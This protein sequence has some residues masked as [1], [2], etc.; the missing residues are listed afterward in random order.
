[1]K[2][3]LAPTPSGFLHAGNGAAFVLAWKLAR[4]AGGRLLLRIDDLDA[5][6]VRPEY[7]KDVFDTLAWLGIEPDEGPR[8]PEELEGAWSQHRRMAGYMDLLDELR[9]TGRL[10]ACDC[11]RKQITGRTGTA[12][13][14]GH[15]RSRGLDLEEPE[16]A[17]RLKV[18]AH[19]KVHLR[20][21][22]DGA[23]RE[24]AL[25]A[26]DPVVRQRNGFP[27][28][29]VASLCDDLLFGV[30][31]IVRGLD[32]LPS[33]LLQ[34][35]MAGLLG[36]KAFGEV[37]FLHHRLITGPAGEK[38]SKSAGAESLGQW[39][40]GGRDPLEIHAL[41]ERLQRDAGS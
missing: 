35:H 32:L 40:K 36:R 24:V 4:Q 6:R 17:W 34:L 39:R 1:M 29:Q 21:W 22:P 15:C 3:R 16:V 20:T 33:T 18:P 9:R 25:A 28:Y 27:A 10:Y 14:D 5:G 31:T 30:D 26:P 8:T 23:R 11:S 19:A 37:V 41:A 38:L 2:T 13:Y 12:E 7:V